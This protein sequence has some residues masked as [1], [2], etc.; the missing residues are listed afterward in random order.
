MKLVI[1]LSNI[2]SE[3][4]INRRNPNVW[5]KLVATIEEGLKWWLEEKR[6]RFLAVVASIYAT[7]IKT[8]SSA[9]VDVA[10]DLNWGGDGRDRGHQHPLPI[11]LGP[12]SLPISLFLTF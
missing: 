2:D 10:G 11:D 1:A 12:S 6:G 4:D 3:E 9:T 8:R 5:A 7:A